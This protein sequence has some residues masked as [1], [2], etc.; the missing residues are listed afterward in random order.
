MVGFSTSEL[1]RGRASD[2]LYDFGNA[3]FEVKIWEAQQVPQAVDLG[4]DAS[5][6]AETRLAIALE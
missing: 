6:L 5:S 3:I 4:D 2:V 1:S